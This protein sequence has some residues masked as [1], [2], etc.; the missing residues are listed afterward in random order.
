MARNIDL[1]RSTIV[2]TLEDVRRLLGFRSRGALNVKAE[3]CRIV[4][5]SDEKLA[6]VLK[7]LLAGDKP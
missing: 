7:S 1:S 5:L 2:G 4:V 6:A 3:R